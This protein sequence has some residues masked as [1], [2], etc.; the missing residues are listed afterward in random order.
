MIRV[1]IS[2]DH[3][4]MREALRMLLSLSQDIELVSETDNGQEAVNSAK[5]IRP[6]VLIMAINLP[7]I[8]GFAA[9]K[10]IADLPIPT[11]VILISLDNGSYILKRAAAVGAQGFVAKDNAARQLL[12]AIKTVHQGHTYFVE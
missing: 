9:T 3:P 12:S 7:V 11:R 8:D 10:Q 5:R 2:E 6:D 4:D 1:A